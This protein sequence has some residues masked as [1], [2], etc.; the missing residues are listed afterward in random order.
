MKPIPLLLCLCLCLATPLP[1]LAIDAAACAALAGEIETNLKQ[2]ALSRMQAATTSDPALASSH[3]QGAD[4]TLKIVDRN[5]QMLVQAGCPAY[6][7]PLE[8][9]GYHN[10]ALH[11]AYD[12]LKQRQDTA[13][14]DQRLWTLK[15]PGE[16]WHSFD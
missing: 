13:P 6:P 1:A 10:D 8:T 9:T 4:R 15:G 16:T 5:V 3:A 14:C 7:Q 11:C 12:L 2:A